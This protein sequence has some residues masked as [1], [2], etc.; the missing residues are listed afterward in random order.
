[1]H[2]D[3]LKELLT[4]NPMEKH[5]KTMNKTLENTTYLIDNNFL[6]CQHKKLHPLT[7]RRG[8]WISETLYRDIEKSQKMIHRNTSLQRVEKI[9]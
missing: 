5:T 4:M 3:G 2:G 7:A 6:L 1:M 8:K 9:Y